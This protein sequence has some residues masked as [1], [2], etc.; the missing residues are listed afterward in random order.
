MEPL[1]P[2]RHG[3]PVAALGRRRAGAGT[4][5][6]RPDHRRFLVRPGAP[7]PPRHPDEPVWSTYLTA[8]GVEIRTRTRVTGFDRDKDRIT[9]VR[10]ERGRLETDAVLIAAGAWTPAVA[11]L[12]GARLPIQAGKGYCLDYAPPPVPVGHALYLHE[13]RVAVTPLDGIIRLAG[14][15]EFSGINTHVRPERI[16]AIA[17]AGATALR[18]W[19]ADPGAATAGTGMRPMT[20]DG[21]PVIGLLKASA[22]SPSP[23]VTPCSAS[24][25]PPPPPTPSPRC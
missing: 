23:A 18:D 6:E 1:R 3:R 10:L 2:V 13:T 7:H 21:L 15:M 4:G 17:R 12:A 5:A 20:P 9:N 22:T 14:T 25:S 24:P 19:P 8:R 16:A 11:R